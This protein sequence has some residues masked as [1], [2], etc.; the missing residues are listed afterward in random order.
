MDDTCAQCRAHPGFVSNTCGLSC[1]P[2]A[3]PTPGWGSTCPLEPETVLSLSWRHLG[4]VCG[5]RAEG[6]QACGAVLLPGR[7]RQGCQRGTNFCLPLCEVVQREGPD[8]VWVDKGSKMGLT[9]AQ[10]MPPLLP[11]LVGG[12]FTLWPRGLAFKIRAEG[13]ATPSSS[14][15]VLHGW[16]KPPA[17]P[18]FLLLFSSRKEEMSSWLQELQLPVSFSLFPGLVGGERETG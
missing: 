10:K 13:T 2:R 16:T 18:L 6:F 14:S 8:V 9:G 5:G 7:P 11:R 4:L 1:L 15:Q 3:W 17:L 12:A